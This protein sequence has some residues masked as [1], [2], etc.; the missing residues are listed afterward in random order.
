MSGTEGS[1]NWVLMTIRLDEEDPTLAQVSDAAKFP[2]TELNQEFGIVPIDRD[3]KLFA[4]Q[5]RE[6]ALALFDD[7]SQSAVKGPFS[8]PKIEPLK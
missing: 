8:N 1:S 7:D 3:Q 6:C 2:I 4:F 5:V